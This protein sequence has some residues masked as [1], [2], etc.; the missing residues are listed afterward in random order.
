MR[1]LF[2]ILLGFGFLVIDSVII[3]A[4]CNMLR[5]THVDFQSLVISLG[6]GLFCVMLSIPGYYYFLDKAKSQG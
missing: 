1:L 5:L 6:L 4:L 2:L 3:L